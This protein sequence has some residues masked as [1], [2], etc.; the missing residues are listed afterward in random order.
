MRRAATTTAAVS[1][2]RLRHIAISLPWSMPA[3]SPPKTTLRD[4]PDYFSPVNTGYGYIPFEV[5]PPPRHTH[6]GRCSAPDAPFERPPVS[7]IVPRRATGPRD[8]AANARHCEG[9]AREKT[10]SR[11]R[12]RRVPGLAPVLATAQGVLRRAVCRQLL[13]QRSSQHR[14][15]ARPAGLRDDAPRHHLPPAS[16]GRRNLPSPLSPLPRPLP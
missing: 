12:R 4:R 3:T 2:D 14:A 10:S 11:D 5:P 15:A 6:S 16:P 7:V 8:G 1:A 13:H 9:D